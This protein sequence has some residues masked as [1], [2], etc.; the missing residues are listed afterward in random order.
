MKIHL[1]CDEAAYHALCVEAA[2]DHKKRVNVD[3]AAL[4][5]LIRDHGKVLANPRAEIV[6][7]YSPATLARAQGGAS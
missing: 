5:A 3:R 2:K 6:D 1:E 7:K 4:A